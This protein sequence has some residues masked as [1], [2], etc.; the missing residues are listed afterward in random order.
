MSPGTKMPGAGSETEPIPLY[1]KKAVPG[2]ADH[3]C[4]AA[5]PACRVCNAGRGARLSPAWAIS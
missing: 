5:H 3:P 1:R 4:A 2:A